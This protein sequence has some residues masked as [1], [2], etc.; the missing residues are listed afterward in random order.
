M[1]NVIEALHDRRLFADSFDDLGTWKSW[2]VFLRALYGLSI[3]EL[4]DLALFQKCTG[5]EKPPERRSREAY[6]ISR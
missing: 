3:T 6:V 1:Q 5:L 2:E 4:E